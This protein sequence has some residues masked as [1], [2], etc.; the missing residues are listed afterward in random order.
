[1]RFV[2]AIVGLLFVWMA[3][4]QLNDP[5]PLYWFVVYVMVAII[6]GARVLGHRLVTVWLIVLGMVIAGLLMSLPGFFDYLMSG[7]YSGIGGHMT[8]EKPYVESGREF[9]GLMIAVV[10]LLAY[11]RHD[12]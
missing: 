7:D 6:P 4:I 9:L 2:H 3:V 5:D 8:D 1:M 11:R 10:C 12:D